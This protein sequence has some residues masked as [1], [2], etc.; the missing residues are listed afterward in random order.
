[1]PLSPD[2][3]GHFEEKQPEA[4]LFSMFDGDDRVVCKVEW[5]ALPDRAIADGAEP[6]D[7]AATFRKH[8]LVIEKIASERYDAGEEMPVVWGCTP[9]QP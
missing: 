3:S 1:M 9:P 7:I 8:R 6:N 5:S 4:V 2:P